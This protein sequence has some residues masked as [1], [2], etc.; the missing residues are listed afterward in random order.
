LRAERIDEREYNVRER[1]NEI[2]EL[3]EQ[4]MFENEY[5][6]KQVQL[7]ETIIKEIIYEG[8]I[9]MECMEVFLHS[10]LSTF[11]DNLLKEKGEIAMKK[12]ANNAAVAN[13]KSP[14]SALRMQ[15]GKDNTYNVP[16]LNNI[17]LNHIPL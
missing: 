9:V 11:F 14:M 12:K 5:W 2:K 17:N 3:R 13:P 8:K 10:D 16:N 6:V 1:Q 15:K 7:H 4:T